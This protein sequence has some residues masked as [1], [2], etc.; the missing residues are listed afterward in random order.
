MELSHAISD[1]ILALVGFFVFFRYLFKL[2]LV[3]CLLWE[4]FVLSVTVAALFG[5]FRFLGF[6]P[7]PLIV[8]E[9]FQHLAGT[10]GALC[11]VFV[12]LFLVLKKPIPVSFAYIVVALGFVAFAVVRLTDNLQVLNIISLVCIPA[13]L[14]LGIWALIKGERSIGAWLILAVVA[15]V[16]GTYNKSFMANSI[17]D[18]IDIYH[19]LLA[20]SLFCFGRAARHQTH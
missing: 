2:D 18:H 15:L 5:A 3:A 9:F 12:T 7:Y 11:L 16:M 1:I 4:A 14:I 8:S 20:I 17:I 6:S 19:Y 13:V 10:V